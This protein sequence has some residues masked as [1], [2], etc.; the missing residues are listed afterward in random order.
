MNSE[1]DYTNNFSSIVKTDN[2]YNKK[3][4]NSN[5]KSP[6]KNKNPKPSLK[7]ALSK[8]RLVSPHG[9]RSIRTMSNGRT[10]ELLSDENNNV[11]SSGK[12]VSMSKFKNNGT[13]II[14]SEDRKAVDSRPADFFEQEYM[15]YRS[16]IQFKKARN[17]VK[18]NKW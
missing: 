16:A 4:N 13:D 8:D 18:L 3:I 14:I 1:K 5:S 17:S 2:I 10:Q 11:L 7:S 9:D 6:S 15:R 12:K